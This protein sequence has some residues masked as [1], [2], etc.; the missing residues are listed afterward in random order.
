[1]EELDYSTV[2]FLNIDTQDFTWEWGSKP[3]TVKAGE[4][5]FYPEFL[6]KHMAKHLSDKLMQER[7][8][9][10]MDHGKRAELVAQ[11]LTQVV[12]E[13]PLT[14]K[15]VVAKTKSGKAKVQK[16]EETPAKDEAFAD[17]NN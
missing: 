2:P 1:M 6:A 10:L 5:K 17:L 4:T 15:P 13:Q 16:V 9:N 11:M 3:Y 14:K 7:D 12:Q 8:I